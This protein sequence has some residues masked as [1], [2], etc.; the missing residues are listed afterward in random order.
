LEGTDPVNKVDSSKMRQ[1][2]GGSPHLGVKV[3]TLVVGRA[4]RHFVDL[5]GVLGALTMRQ[6]AVEA[7][8]RPNLKV[9]EELEIYPWGSSKTPKDLLQNMEEDLVEARGG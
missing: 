1:E 2:I 5:A 9:E 8:A 6:Y 7:G 3:T 4:S